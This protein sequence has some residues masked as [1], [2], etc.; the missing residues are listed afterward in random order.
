MYATSLADVHIINMSLGAYFPKNAVGG[1]PLVAA[2]NKAVN[3]AGSKGKLVVTAAGNDFSDLDHDG[4]FASVPAQSGSGISAWAGD[5]DGGLAVYSNHGR[6]GAWVGAGGGD[7]KGSSQ[8]PLAGC[9]LNPAGQ[10]GIAS[11]C[12]QFS[13]FFSCGPTSVLF[14]GT[15]T[16]FSAPMVAGVAALVDGKAGGSLSGGQLKTILART[17]DDVGRNGVD[18]LFSHGR[19]NAGNAVMY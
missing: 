16:S 13:I 18:N 17:A 1:G 3:H 19:V 15:G 12:S 10:E 6:S 11:V 14:G 7:F 8:I 2:M 5:I 4:N 9:L